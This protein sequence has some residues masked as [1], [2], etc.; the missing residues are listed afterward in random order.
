MDLDSVIVRAAVDLPWLHLSRIC[1]SKCMLGRVFTLRT[2]FRLVSPI[3]EWS[4]AS[5]PFGP[6][7]P[8]HPVPSRWGRPFTNSDYGV[9]STAGG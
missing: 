5:P 1:A 2:A 8:V 3:C 6:L 4:V 7:G 9:I